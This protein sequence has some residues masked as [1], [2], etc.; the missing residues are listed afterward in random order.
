MALKLLYPCGVPGGAKVTVTVVGLMTIAVREESE[1][2]VLQPAMEKARLAS[3]SALT[4]KRSI[5]EISLRIGG[6]GHIHSR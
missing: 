1:V 4:H 2:E 6:F 5:I 3:S